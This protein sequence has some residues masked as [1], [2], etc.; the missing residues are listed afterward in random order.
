MHL[1][2]RA[3]IDGLRAIAILCVLLYHAN[4]QWLPGGFVGVDIFFVISGFLITQ[5]IAKDLNADTFSFCEFYKRRAKRILPA[6]LTVLTATL[7]LGWF[8][9]MDDELARLGKH[10]FAAAYFGSNF[11]LLGE[12]GDYFDI[13]AE[14]KPLLHLWS[15]AIEEQFYLLWPVLLL[16]LHKFNLSW[17]WAVALLLGASLIACLMLTGQNAVYAFYMP[18]TRFWELG[19][20]ALLALLVIRRGWSVP[21]GISKNLL[22]ALG[23]LLIAVAAILFTREQPYPGWRALLPVA[24]AV[25]LMAAGEAAWVNRKVLA[26]RLMVGI[27]RISY[28]LYLWH[29]P[30]LA[31]L[32]VTLPEGVPAYMALA[33]LVLSVILAIITYYAI[34]NPIRFGKTLNKKH[35]GIVAVSL[36]VIL[37]CL[38]GLGELTKSKDGFPERF[39]SP[40]AREEFRTAEA[41]V[42]T[43]DCKSIFPNRKRGSCRLSDAGTPLSVVMIGDSHAKS[44]YPGLAAYYGKNGQSFMS[45]SKA[46]CPPVI[47]LSHYKDKS[48]AI[49]TGCEVIQNGFNWVLTQPGIKTVILAARGTLYVQDKDQANFFRNDASEHTYADMLLTTINT[50]EQAGKTV[51]LLADSPELNFHPNACLTRPLMDSLVPHETK[52]CTASLQSVSTH[53]LAYRHSLNK[54]LAQKPGV[55]MFDP[56]RVIC[57][58]GNTCHFMQNGGL[59]YTDE[60]HLSKYGAYRVFEGFGGN[61]F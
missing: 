33:A 45:I 46:S 23:L 40:Q 3:D 8:I 31:Y 34:E 10:I 27:G 9:L 42:H 18:F 58:D 5:I 41:F 22:A 1:K 14:Q 19:A 12:Q 15:L 4:A 25:L 26:S 35:G 7:G 49:H 11:T 50:L 36:C 51:I 47:G 16:L 17:R 21:Q 2:Y 54:V 29:W 44:F 52:P 43:T 37:L 28:P 48:G 55:S 53:S 6:L 32:H 59:F 24:G 38:G 39:L 61:G 13:T 30:L 57:A 56:Q 20:G 60:N